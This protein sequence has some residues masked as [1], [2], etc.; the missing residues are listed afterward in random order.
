ME[1]LVGMPQSETWAIASLKNKVHFKDNFNS[2]CRTNVCNVRW[3]DIFGLEAPKRIMKEAVV[4]PIKYPQLFT[5]MFI[6]RSYFGS[7]NLILFSNYV[8]RFSRVTCFK[9]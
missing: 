2:F 5:G 7:E 3:T 4:Y 6:N 9:P 1:E 8:E